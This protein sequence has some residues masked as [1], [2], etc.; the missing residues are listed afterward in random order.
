MTNS[1]ATPV[2]GRPGAEAARTAVG[3]RPPG[4]QGR[5]PGEAG[6]TPGAVVERLA[7]ERATGALR[8]PGGTVYL[9]DGL[10]AHAESDRAPDLATLLTACGRLSPEAWQDAVRRFGPHG[11][12]GEGLVE[13]GR[14][15][16]GELEL[17]HLGALFDAACFLLDA[18]A[19]T[20]AAP[21]RWTFAPG[22]RHWLGP[23]AAVG[24]HR[25]RREAER[26]RHLLDRI[27]PSAQFDTAPLCRTAAPPT[28]AAPARHARRLRP[29]TRRQCELL[30][31][32]DGRR[33]PAELARLLGRSAFATPADVRRLAAAGLL[34]GPATG[35]GAGAGCAAGTLPGTGDGVPAPRGPG[36]LHRRV[37]GAA[38]AALSRGRR[39]PEPGAAPLTANDP[40]VALL[41][42]VRTLL[43][44]RL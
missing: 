12:V 20:L 29:P 6:W 28:T 5:P 15:T 16:R 34:T 40:D 9:V 21:A 7:G 13:Q 26:R 24:A 41:V 18:P 19:T 4:G 14:L 2:A 35:A 11:R 8:G 36:G 10:V 38:L 44:A 23:V 30:D 31:H 22:V 33:T 3:F 27:W 37:P 1:D 42:R 32:A 39:G 17:C 43:E 25:L